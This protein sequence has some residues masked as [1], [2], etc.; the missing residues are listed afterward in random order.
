M[1]PLPN[2][3][4]ECDVQRAAR[5]TMGEMTKD[6]LDKMLKAMDKDGDGQCSKVSKPG[7]V[8]PA[9]TCCDWYPGWLLM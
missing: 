8:L 7:P 3:V 2:A 1:S 5:G 4:A 9:C 6:I